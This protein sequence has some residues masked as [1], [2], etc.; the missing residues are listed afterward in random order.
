MSLDNS[1][2]VSYTHGF[3]KLTLPTVP[4][5]QQGLSFPSAQVP[6]PLDK[7]TPMV[8]MTDVRICKYQSWFPFYEALIAS[9]RF[10]ICT[11]TIC[12]YSSA[13]RI[14]AIPTP[15]VS[16]LPAGSTRYNGTS[17]G[18]HT[19]GLDTLLTLPVELGVVFTPMS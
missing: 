2:G 5:A 7:R 15:H 11:A 3:V 9:S 1:L 14:E 19:R 8:S 17:A 13:P 12:V 10:A 18:L 6:A 16:R 4:H